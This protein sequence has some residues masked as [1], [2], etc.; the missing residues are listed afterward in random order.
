MED[1]GD[2]SS[3]SDHIDFDCAELDMKLETKST[4]GIDEFLT[5]FIL[6]S[7]CIS[8]KLLH[9]FPRSTYEVCN[10]C[11]FD[12]V[13]DIEELPPIKTLLWILRYCERI[14]Q[15]MLHMFEGPI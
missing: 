15:L 1:D 7:V 11:F 8:E 2:D 6:E 4:F 9:S 3:V 14:C 13:V 10:I 5:N 12:V